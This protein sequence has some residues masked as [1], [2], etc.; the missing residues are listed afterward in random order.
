M[1]GRQP[2]TRNQPRLM[3]RSA[4]SADRVGETPP[5]GPTSAARHRHMP[6]IGDMISVSATFFC[7]S[8][9]TSYSALPA[10]AVAFSES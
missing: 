8:V 7:A 2:V 9:R 4:G 3:R 10:A 6:A 5:P 1:H